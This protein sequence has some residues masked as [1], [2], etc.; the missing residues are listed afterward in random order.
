MLQSS[1]FGGPKGKNVIISKIYESAADLIANELGSTISPVGY[2]DYVLIS[3]GPA[4][5]NN[6]YKENQ[7]KDKSLFRSDTVNYNGKIYKKEIGVI[8]AE[9]K[10]IPYNILYNIN[11]NIGADVEQ[12]HFKLVIDLIVSAAPSELVYKLGDAGDETKLEHKDGST[13]ELTWCPPSYT[14]VKNELIIKNNG[15][16]VGSIPVQSLDM[17]GNNFIEQTANLTYNFQDSQGFE[18]SLS[19][20][21]N[22]NATDLDL[23]DNT[24]YTLQCDCTDSQN[25]N[26]KT[27]AM[28][29]IYKNDGKTQWAA[30]RPPDQYAY[31]EIQLPA[32]VTR[33]GITT[34]N[35][36]T[37]INNENGRIYNQNDLLP[38]QT[39]TV[40]EED[41]EREWH[42]ADIIMN[43]EQTQR[44]I[45]SPVEKQLW[46]EVQDLYKYHSLVGREL[47]SYT[48][49]DGEKNNRFRLKSTSSS[50]DIFLDSDTL[51]N[52]AYM[53][54][55]EDGD[56]NSTNNFNLIDISE[57]YNENH[58]KPTSGMSKY[59]IEYEFNPDEAG[60]VMLEFTNINLTDAS[61]KRKE[62]ISISP[63][64]PK[65]YG[66][67]ELRVWHN[68]KNS[69]ILYPNSVAGDYTATHYYREIMNEDG[70][71]T[72]TQ[73]TMP[74]N[75]FF[76]SI[77]TNTTLSNKKA[78]EVYYSNFGKYFNS[79]KVT[80]YDSDNSWALL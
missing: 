63:Y 26:L 45:A 14:I 36:I 28:V 78:T 5:D 4:G 33:E 19:Q 66:K 13:Y 18:T 57:N 38:G 44:Y 80:K 65:R 15:V 34:H 72:L 35:G 60:N 16:E 41:A 47:F 48:R 24:W 7:E 39:V 75:H 12:I 49:N 54:P 37:R 11:A 50:Y 42:D 56:G 31:T 53:V 79:F 20:W 74:L 59:V 32:Y 46:K 73:P 1:F 43:Q 40:T 76:I 67:I 71:S 64:L 8:S 58:P 25:K 27:K 21:L 22:N 62:K 23:A 6:K 77:R 68:A 55:L 9:A 52:N 69:D 61:K 2:G 10:N 29:F 17:P 30:I 3:Y 51:I 70:Y